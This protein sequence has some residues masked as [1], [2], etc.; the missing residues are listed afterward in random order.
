MCEEW[1]TGWSPATGIRRRRGRRRCRGR[2]SAP[3]PGQLLDQGAEPPRDDGAPGVDADHGHAL[4]VRIGL[5]LSRGRCERE[6]CSGRPGR[7]RSR[8]SLASARSLWGVAGR[9]GRRNFIKRDPSWPRWTGLKEPTREC[10]NGM[11]WRPPVR[12]PAATG[13]PC[14]RLRSRHPSTH[15]RGSPRSRRASRSGRS[16]GARPCARRP[17]GP[18]SI[19]GAK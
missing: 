6:L 4:A 8:R 14:S 18:L 2:R 3:A 17:R 5:R 9:L 13:S 11:G 7:G 10:S 19:A 12:E 1:T 15:E 16:P